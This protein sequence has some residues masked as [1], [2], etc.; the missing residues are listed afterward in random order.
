M[1]D[2][3]MEFI[4]T[5]FLVMVVGLTGNPIAIGMILAV[6]VYMGGHIS[7]AHY[8]PAV[9]LAV[10]LRGFIKKEKV[11]GYVISQL[12]AGFASVSVLL[13]LNRAFIPSPTLG[14][15]LEQAYVVEILFTF[16]LA[17]VILAVATTKKLKGN[18]IYGLAIGFTLMAIAYA[19]GPIS[20]GMYNP[21]VA[22]GPIVL[23]K[24][25]VGDPYPANLILLYIAGPLAGG[26]LAAF[27]YKYLNGKKS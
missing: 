6:M 23:S 15:T 3:V 17:S 4:G 14:V 13:F 24:I 12:L 11:P 10:W 25:I 9:T 18:Y 26:A 19:G 8:N 5:F 22:L 16:A 7:G 21:A 27:V 1:K 2:Y 20:G